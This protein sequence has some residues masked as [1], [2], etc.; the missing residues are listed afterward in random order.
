MSFDLYEKV[1]VWLL[2][3]AVVSSEIWADS[4]NSITFPGNVDVLMYTDT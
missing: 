1:S 4:L 2:V 3:D